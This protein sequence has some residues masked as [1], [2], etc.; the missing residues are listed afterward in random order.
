MEDTTLG[1]AIILLVIAA[2][3][4]IYVL[5]WKTIEH[6]IDTRKKIWTNFMSARRK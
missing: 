4:L 5:V 2:S 3:P 1:E 6:L